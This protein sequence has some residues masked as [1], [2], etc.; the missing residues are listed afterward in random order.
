MS[1]E[2]A[3][4]LY[5]KSRSFHVN[6]DL[7]FSYSWQGDTYDGY[8]EITGDVNS[9]IYTTFEE[10][11]PATMSEMVCLI[12]NFYGG[13]TIG[14]GHISWQTSNGGSADFNINIYGELLIPVGYTPILKK[15]T[16][17][18]TDLEATY[19][20]PFVFNAG[21]DDDYGGSL[22]TFFSPTGPVTSQQDAFSLT[23]DDTTFTTTVYANA[24]LGNAD[25]LSLSCNFQMTVKDA[26]L[27]E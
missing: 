10:A 17:Q 13:G 16:P 14:N 12:P 3:M 27:A 15:K 6:G 22:S 11:W 8:S 5:W 7:N 24:A 18:Q 26:R 20:I 4:S 1:L 25:G 23:I 19:F 2:K 21:A 9:H